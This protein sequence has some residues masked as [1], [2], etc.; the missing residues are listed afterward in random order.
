M[1]KEDSQKA[2]EKTK[3]FFYKKVK[4]FG[5][6][7][8]HLLPHVPE[9]ERW[10]N[11]VLE[12]HP[13]ANKEIVILGVWLHDIGHYPI[14]NIDHAIT[15]EKIALEFLKSINLDKVK[16][17][18]VAKCV[19][20]HRCKDIL[21]EAIEEKIIAF[22]D[23]ASH[24]TTPMYFDMMMR[25]KN[26]PNPAVYDAINKIERDFRDLSYFPE[27]K[28]QMRELYEDWKRL[29]ITYKNLNSK[30]LNK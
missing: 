9:V 3:E 27:I 24:M 17:E 14:L 29:L 2:I 12:K 19:R 26:D 30:T 16:I 10:A 5:S 11:F 13:E 21:P 18:R 4:D 15:G 8:Y 6:D 22:S 20:R 25:D 7:P 23:S 28:E 1:L